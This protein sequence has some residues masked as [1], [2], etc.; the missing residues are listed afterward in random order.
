MS[1]NKVLAE[2]GE[3]RAVLVLD[4]SAPE[5]QDD[6]AVPQF[7]AYSHYG[8]RVG[9]GQNTDSLPDTTEKLL[10]AWDEL[11]DRFDGQ[12]DEMFARYCRIV[13]GAEYVRV[14]DHHGYS[15]GDEIKLFEI[16]GKGWMESM[17][18][19]TS[20]EEFATAHE[21]YTDRPELVSYVYGDVWGIVVEKNIRYVNPDDPEDFVSI[22]N[23]ISSCWGYYG[24]SDT[25]YF[26]EEAESMLEE[27]LV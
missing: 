23:T 15:Q 8:W 18:I 21:A 5:P 19:K 6:G 7:T 14:T 27:A 12:G 16:A 25:P 17:G 20:K 22:W 10:K 1:E 3:Y 9:C 4:E 2:Q 24:E 26:L 13:Y 11:S